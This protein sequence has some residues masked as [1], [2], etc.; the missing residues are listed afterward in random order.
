[1][2]SRLCEP[3]IQRLR[4]LPQVVGVSTCKSPAICVLIEFGTLEAMGAS[5]GVVHGAI[6]EQVSCI[7]ILCYLTGM[8][9][10]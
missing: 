7:A 8:V 10:C 6:A 1:M 4:L 5:E 9:I 3:R 2:E